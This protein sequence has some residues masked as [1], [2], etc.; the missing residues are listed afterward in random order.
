MRLA[1]RFPFMSCNPIIT[2]NIFNLR[3]EGDGDY[4]VFINTAGFSVGS[5]SGDQDMTQIAFLGGG[6]IMDI[7]DIGIFEFDVIPAYS[8]EGPQIN[9]GALGIHHHLFLEIIVKHGNP[10]HIPE[11]RKGRGHCPE[12][13]AGR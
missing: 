8:L 3:K 11:S 5:D 13:Q 7:M 2:L 9:K 10:L 6:G 1:I 4:F 12:G